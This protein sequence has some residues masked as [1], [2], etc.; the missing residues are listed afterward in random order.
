MIAATLVDE[1]AADPHMPA[2][3]ITPVARGPHEPRSNGW[4]SLNLH[5]WRSHVDVD[6]DAGITY[7]R[8]GD[9]AGGK[10]YQAQ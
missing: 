6:S 9:A 10:Q 3:L 1:M 8:S 4:Y 5:W 2:A 7:G